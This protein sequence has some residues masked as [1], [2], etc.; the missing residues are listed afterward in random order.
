MSC[1][2]NRGTS[3]RYARSARRAATFPPGWRRT[4]R[5]AALIWLVV[6][7]ADPPTVAADDCLPVKAWTVLDD[8]VRLCAYLTDPQEV[9]A[10]EAR[11][12]RL[13]QGVDEHEAQIALQALLLCMDEF[14]IGVA[15]EDPGIEPAER[16]AVTTATVARADAASGYYDQGRVRILVRERGSWIEET[17]TRWEE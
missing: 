15:R 3:A 13:G 17:I 16:L 9:A 11:G 5:A 10:C 8:P 2:S 12:F 4:I 1:R 14:V 7:P 6:L